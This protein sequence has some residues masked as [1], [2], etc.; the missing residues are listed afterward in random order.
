MDAAMMPLYP[1]PACPIPGGPCRG[2]YSTFDKVPFVVTP[3]RFVADLCELP[4][5]G[6]SNLL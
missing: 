2:A 1:A 5:L 3:Q 6:T 4:A